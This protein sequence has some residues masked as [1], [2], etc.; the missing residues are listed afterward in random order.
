LPFHEGGFSFCLHLALPVLSLSIPIVSYSTRTIF[1][2]LA[3]ALNSEYCWAARARGVP[4]HRVLIHHALRSSVGPIGT[5]LGMQF[6]LLVSGA[7]V[8]ERVFGIPG[9]GSLSIDAVGQR[10]IPVVLGTTL[11]LSVVTL[12]SM[13]AAD[14]M[15]AHF[16]P[17]MRNIE[18]S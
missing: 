13:L 10:D 16:D 5:V 4:E 17:R 11:L 7:V 3:N 14:V 2:V 6:P 15:T 12:L 8:I 9:M 1:S 18:P